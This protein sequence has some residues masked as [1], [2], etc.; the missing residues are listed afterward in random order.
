MCG[1]AGMMY[2]DPRQPVDPAALRQM[3]ATIA[4]RG[5][6]AEACWTQPGIGLVHRRL[7]I[8]DL[9][10]GDQPMGNEDGSIQVVFNG[11]IYNYRALRVE[12]E[13]K[14]HR[15]STNSDTEVLV[16]LY[17]EVGEELVHRLRGMFAFALWDERNRR[18]LLARDR[19][20][21]K[22]LY[23]YRDREKLLFGSEIKP[24]LVDLTVDRSIDAAALEDYL[25]FGVITGQRSIFRSIQKLPPGHTLSISP[26]E[27]ESSPRRYWRLHCDADESLS[28]SDWLDAVRAKF[29]ETVTAHRIA[30]VPVGAFLSGGLDSSAVTAAFVESGAG[31]IQTF[32]IGFQDERFSELPYARHVAKRFGTRHVEQ[33]VTPEAVQSLDDLVTY[34]DEPFADP[35]AIPTMSV[36]RLARQYVKVVLSGDGGDEAFGGYARYAHDLKEAAVRAWLPGFVRRSLLGP[37]SRIWPRTDW[38]PRQMRLKSA[39]TNLSLD[40]S[41]AYA[42]T[43]SVCRAPL[44][45]SLL[46]PNVRGQ[47]NGHCPESQVV[48]AFEP[49]SGDP[50]RG[51]I[52]SDIAMLLPDD[53]LTKVDRASMAVGLEVRPPLVDHEFLELSARI[54]SS[55][56]VR[57]GETKWLFKQMCDGWLPDEV[58]HRPKQGFDIPVDDWLRGPLR[59]VFEAN[60]LSRS[61]KVSQL[62]DQ[63]NVRRVYD[64]HLRRSGRYGNTLWAILV[65]GAWAERYLNSQSQQFTIGASAT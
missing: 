46:H 48:N 35:S 25:T 15:F 4:H 20:G 26:G 27:F 12:L 36:A 21:L 41:F 24:L 34:Y 49:P 40:D 63:S 62:I 44:R 47:L 1:I 8:I 31:D 65:L 60:V 14:G 30:D 10:G 9:A 3:A 59:D 57:G 19:V 38:L 51:M 58:V 29:V 55:L 50:L 43:I 64:A 6:D 22:P 53:F 17:E 32:S 11:E 18:L 52:A 37:M 5:P 45:R 39:L 61:A 54:P 16:H 7:S 13:Q 56:K 33:I 28:V 2:A 23:Y 42:N